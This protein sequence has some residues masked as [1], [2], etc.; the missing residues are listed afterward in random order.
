MRERPR[1]RPR[2]GGKKRLVVPRK[3]PRQARAVATVEA[4]LDATAR[5]LV[6]D[7]YHRM[8]TNRVAEAAG[9][10][11]GSLYEYFP[12]KEALVMALAERHE[13]AA[14]AQVER[15]LAAHVGA[16]LSAALQ[17]LVEALL[18]A[19]AV[20]PQLHRALHE[21]LPRAVRSPALRALDERVEQIARAEL[22]AR[23]EL[24][25]RDV[26][27]AAF[28]ITNVL[29]TLTHRAVIDRPDILARPGLAAEIT[30]LVVGYVAPGARAA[31]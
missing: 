24:T 9:V 13:Q 21:E 10:S 23:P 30:A 28:V 18:A 16:P 1:A 31:T 15:S 7:G 29:E 19:H 4:I 6:K 14:I 17:H 11:I 5:I 26:D 3:T 27:L 25:V 2:T 8:T 22:R 20:H 12:S